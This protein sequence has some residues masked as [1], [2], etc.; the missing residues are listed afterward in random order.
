MRDPWVDLPT[1]PSM[2]G[3]LPRCLGHQSLSSNNQLSLRRGSHQRDGVGGAGGQATHVLPT[4]Y[5]EVPGQRDEGEARL[6]A[7]SPQTFLERS[8]AAGVSP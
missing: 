3:F 5:E 4:L 1:I 7:S 2:T 6:A 8:R